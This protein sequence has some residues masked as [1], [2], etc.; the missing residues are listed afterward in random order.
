ML[1]LGHFG[2]MS[3]YILQFQEKRSSKRHEMPK[4]EFILKQETLFIY[5]Y[6]QCVLLFFSLSFLSHH[7][8]Q[9]SWDH[10]QG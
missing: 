4:F 10:R 8:N 1:V 5:L 2:S 3:V 7:F 9:D 6:N